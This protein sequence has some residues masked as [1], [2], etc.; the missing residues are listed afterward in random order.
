MTENKSSSNLVK[1]V[2]C[3][4]SVAKSARKCPECSTSFPH[5]VECTICHEPIKR[6]YALVRKES[7]ESRNKYYHPQCVARMLS[8]PSGTVCSDCGVPIDNSIFPLKVLPASNEYAKW[9]PPCPNCGSQPVLK[10]RGNGLCD[11]CHLPILRFHRLVKGY[12]KEMDSGGYYE[13]NKPVFFHE[14]CVENEKGWFA[15]ECIK[16]YQDVQ[17]E[18]EKAREKEKSSGCLASVLLFIS[19]SMGLSGWLLL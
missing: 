14:Q 18:K 4:H 16:R 6:D 15:K 17:Q 8:I 3:G 1:C 10:G 9:W 2:E 11:L 5:G 19:F 7:Y 13:V 12:E